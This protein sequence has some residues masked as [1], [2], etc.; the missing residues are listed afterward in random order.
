MKN[1]QKSS[2][3]KNGVQA[4]LGITN[5]DMRQI[6]FNPN[7]ALINNVLTAAAAASVGMPSAVVVDPAIIPTPQSVFNVQTAAA[8]TGF[9]CI[10]PYTN[11]TQN[12]L[13]RQ[14][15]SNGQIGNTS[16]LKL[17]TNGS[18]QHSNGIS[19]LI[20]GRINRGAAGMCSAGFQAFIN[21]SLR[22]TAN[23]RRKFSEQ[24]ILDYVIS[25]QYHQQQQI[26][27][28]S[29]T[30]QTPQPLANPQQPLFSP[31]TG[32]VI[33]P[34]GTGLPVWYPAVATPTTG[35]YVPLIPAAPLSI[36]L[37]QTAAAAVSE[38]NASIPVSVPATV[39]TVASSDESSLPVAQ[40]QTQQG[41]QLGTS[42]TLIPGGHLLING[43]AGPM[44]FANYQQALDD[45][46]REQAYGTTQLERTTTLQQKDA[47]GRELVFFNYK[48]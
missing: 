21:N 15:S 44:P 2:G 48:A 36:P 39:T 22:H 38:L 35:G 11:T 8:L 29:S 6:Y 3:R 4:A 12:L 28:A 26:Q 32:M 20:G 45:Y 42:V 10:D 16:S 5:D 37:P 31:P 17:L 7:P 47:S 1:L 13:E 14:N 23:N 9:P 40:Q 25:Q 24:F 19:P 41:H 34:N 30:E 18:L 27:Q 33:L 46:C 43:G